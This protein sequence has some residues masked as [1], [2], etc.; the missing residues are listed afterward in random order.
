MS[1]IT[2]TPLHALFGAEVHGF[3]WNNITQ[4][5]VDELRL[6]LA[7]YGIVVARQTG[8]DDARH[9]AMSG[10]FGEL[11]DIKPYSSQG[12]I[13]RLAYDELF[14]VSNINADGSIMQPTGDR[15]LMNRGNGLFHVDSA[16]NPRRAGYS[17]LLAHELPPPGYCAPTQFADSRT[18]YD[19]LPAHDKERIADWV[20]W[21]S[22]HHSRR[23]ACP[24]VKL[25]EEAR[26]SPENH[27]FGK[28]RLVQLHEASGRTNMYIANHA[29]KVAHLPV[30]EGQ[31]EIQKL[32]DHA[33]QDKYILTVD[34]Q[35]PG[36]LVIWDN[37][38]VMHRVG[39]AEGPEGKYKRDMR[40]TTVHD[41]SSTAWGENVVGDTW[42][43][44]LP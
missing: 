18:A 42:R 23:K 38:C 2:Y 7:K 27:P 36:D 31:A 29:Y 16:F 40:R 8:L 1:T 19:D 4:S 10:M 15:A 5:T 25:F 9:V 33:S 30:E 32:L 34:W 14:D 21:H 44:G 17:L 26:F 28:H 13:N 22:N 39:K 24:G 6:G 37:T 20:L 3:D 43:S 12:R 41:S 35:N 11:D